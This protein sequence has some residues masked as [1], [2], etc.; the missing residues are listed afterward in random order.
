[1]RDRAQ[2]ISRPR[3]VRQVDLGFDFFFA[4]QWTRGPRRRCLP[5]S[6][7]ADIGPHFFRFMVFDR[8]GV[9][10]LLSHSDERQSVENGLAFH[11]KLSR[12]IVDS[13][14]TH[15]A[16]LFPALGL[17]RNLTE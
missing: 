9:R 12:K 7:A 8:T 17:H 13:N 14:L 11:F 1:L 3:D 6:R 4:A 10:L 2:H 15:P 5:F 16:F